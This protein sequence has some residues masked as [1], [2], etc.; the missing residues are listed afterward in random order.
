MINEFIF[1][2]HVIFVTATLLLSIPFGVAGLTAVITVQA[3]IANIFVVKQTVLFGLMTTCA[4]AFTVG[5]T[6]GLAFITQNYGTQKA[7]KTL[8]ITLLNLIFW[9]C[10]TKIHLSY[11]PLGQ[12]GIHD[13]CLSLFSH[14][15]RII[16]ASF[17]AYAIAETCNYLIVAALKRWTGSFRPMICTSFAALVSQLI[18]TTLFAFLALKGI[19]ADLTHV[20]MAC[21][22]IKVIAI[23]CINPFLYC[24]RFLFK[25]PASH[26]S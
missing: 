15:P 5:S 14:A 19:V 4:E 26:D 3:I 21:Y 1:I 2:L 16:I 13:A 7:A 18:D 11:A 17:C 23:L 20:I 10:V 12:D 9:G 24:T 8:A 25:L 6:L 22:A